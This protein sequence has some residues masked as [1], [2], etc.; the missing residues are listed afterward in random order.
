MATT[1]AMVRPKVTTRRYDDPFFVGMALAILATVVLGFG[2]TYF[3]RGAVLAKLPSVLVHVH[4][5]IFSSWVILYVVQNVL[6]AMK[7]IK[8]HRTL[9]T[10]G[11][12]LA[13]LMVV[14]GWATTVENVRR[15]ATPPIFTAG[16]FLVLNCWGVTLFALLVGWAILKRNEGPAHKRIMLLATVGILPP[17]ITRFQLLMHWPGFAVLL[18]MLAMA[19]P[20]VFFD[21]WTRKRPHYA[22][23][24]TFVLIFSV[25]PTSIALGH[26]AWMQGIV[27][28]LIGHA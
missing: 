27:A 18:W 1:A 6:V 13:G 14:L 12:V 25:R 10:C 24:I 17:A 26:T 2:P 11:G 15:G 7:K 19:L 9:G 8:W 22:T 28:R 5:A 21:V 16:E 4:G 20:L 3:Y 23:L